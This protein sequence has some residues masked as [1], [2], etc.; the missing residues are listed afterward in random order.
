MTLSAL[1][2][3]TSSSPLTVLSVS[4][5]SLLP[6]DP[7]VGNRRKFDASPSPLIAPFAA[8]V[9]RVHQPHRT[10]GAF[11][12]RARHCSRCPELRARPQHR[13]VPGS[14]RAGVVPLHLRELLGCTWDVRKHVVRCTVSWLG[15]ER[16][17]GVPVPPRHCHHSR[18]FVAWFCCAASR[19]YVLPSSRIKLTAQRGVAT[20][21]LTG[22]CTAHAALAQIRNWRRRRAKGSSG[23]VARRFHDPPSSRSLYRPS[24]SK[25]F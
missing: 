1:L 23:R 22:A 9:R 17:H 11:R 8:Y 12:Q 4:A 20:H 13:T 25:S 21:V 10:H 7:H 19:V 5:L 2:P 15:R 16:R 18:P 3:N 24:S 6:H 14:P